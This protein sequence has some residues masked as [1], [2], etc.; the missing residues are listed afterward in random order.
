MPEGRVRRGVH[1]Y[2]CLLY[3]LACFNCVFLSVVITMSEYLELPELDGTVV[4]KGDP[5]PENH[6]RPNK[7]AEPLAPGVAVPEKT[8]AQL[9]V[10][11]ANSDVVANREDKERKKQQTKPAAK[12][13]SAAGPSSPPK[14]RRRLQVDE[15]VVES[16]EHTVDANPLNQAEPSD[17]AEQENQEPPVHNVEEEPHSLDKSKDPPVEMFEERSHK[18]PSDGNKS[19]RF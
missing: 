4:S 2:Y 19:F 17:R 15:E 7:T 10:E 1:Y 5:L 14:R 12:K 9:T 13:R 18:T 11:A 16:E 8:Y 6:T 3:T